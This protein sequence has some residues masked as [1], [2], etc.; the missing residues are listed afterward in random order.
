MTMDYLIRLVQ[1]HQDFRLAEIR[2]LAS[3]F[4]IK[5]EIVSYTDSSP[6]LIVRILSY[7]ASKFL[8]PNSA[9]K[10]CDVWSGT[11]LRK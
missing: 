7:P 10:A 6:F 8:S 1:V 5:V 11:S 4:S 9:A 2:S 3:Y